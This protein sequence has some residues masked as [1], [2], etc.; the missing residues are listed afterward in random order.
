MNKS[1]FIDFKKALQFMISFELASPL[2]IRSGL[3]GEFTDSGIERDFED[4][5]HINGYVWASLFRRALMRVKGGDKLAYSIGKYDAVEGG[6]SALWTESSFIY[7]PQET[8][9][10][11]PGNRIDRTLGSAAKGA[12]FSDE[13]IPPGIQGDL[14]FTLFM[15]NDDNA[16][17]LKNLLFKAFSVINGGIETIGGGWSY[18]LGRLKLSKRG[19]RILNLKNPEDQAKLWK[20]YADSDVECNDKDSTEAATL[21]SKD[22]SRPWKKYTVTAKISDG[23]LLAVHTKVPLLAE[24]DKYE[25]YPDDFVYQRYRYK[26]NEFVAEPVIPGRTIRQALFAVPI[27][28]MLRSTGEACCSDAGTQKNGC[29]C[30]RCTWFGST[31][32]GG[33]ISA[34][35]AVIEK[36]ETIVLNRVQLCEHTMQNLQLFN[37]EYLSGGT[38]SFDI[39]IDEAR[40]NSAGLNDKIKN[41]L[42]ELAGAIDAPPGWYRIG[43][44]STCTGQISVTKVEPPL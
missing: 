16:D 23:Q 30:K 43:A 8:T 21:E 39:V 19:F 2:M 1:T 18:G 10:V 26:D 33:I 38:F 27:E 20:K 4:R 22:I 7:L 6:V 3:Q 14:K 37:G 41:I 40:P 17:I 32:G 12:L 35:D 24:Y 36:A 25:E 31:V 34:S 15:T 13:I 28:R 11:R 29:S 9:D 5:L 42:D 44:T